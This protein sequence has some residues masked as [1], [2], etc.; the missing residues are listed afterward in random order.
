ML[1]VKNITG[2]L[3]VGAGPAGLMLAIEL[4]RR[5]IDV[6]LI[7]QKPGTT[8]NPQANATQARTM[9]YFRRL[10]FSDEIR[11]LGLPETYPTDI[12]YTTRFAGYELARIRLPSIRD[13]R[14][15]IREKSSTWCSAELPHRISQ[16]FVETVLRSKVEELSTVSVRFNCRLTDF[17]SFSDRIEVCSQCVLTGETYRTSAVYLAG[18][19]GAGSFVRKSIGAGLSGESG[20]KRPFMGGRM[21]AVYLRAP[22]IYKIIPHEKAWMHVTFNPDRRAFMAA[23]DGL[24]EFAFHT[25]LNSDERDRELSLRQSKRLVVQAFGAKFDMEILS[26]GDWEAGYSLVSDCFWKD[27]IFL[28]GDA[29]HLFT[30]TGGL[31]YNTA[32]EDAVNLGWKLAAVIRGVGGSGLLRS[33]QDER[34]PLAQ[35]NTGYARAFADSLGGFEADEIVE[36]NN[37]AGAL[38]RQRIGEYF[39]NHGRQEFNIPGITFGGRYESSPVILPDGTEPPPDRPNTYQQSAC[40]GGRPPHFWLNSGESAFDLFGREWTLLC[41]GKDS[42]YEASELSHAASRFGCPLKVV[43]VAGIEVREL[44]EAELAL[45]RPD[46]I[47]AW[48]GSFRHIDPDSIFARVLGHSF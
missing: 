27:R 3:I 1:S 11:E 42:V 18:C 4:G 39:A 2:V 46:Q 17:E 15:L 31:G 38:E 12:V 7:E 13:A 6:Q 20:V 37:A 40:P 25:Q 21:H 29:A 8:P 32:V 41:L 35:R 9:E 22:D 28:L 43:D 34:Q 30:P 45:I 48:R 19:D 16:K 23:V 47:V 26:R 44:Y 36:E 5:G 10:G 33:Y 14:Q 24:G